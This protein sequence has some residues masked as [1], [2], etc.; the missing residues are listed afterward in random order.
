[1]HRPTA[2]GDITDQSDALNTGAITCF[3]KDAAGER[4]LTTI[5][6][7]LYRIVAAN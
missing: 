4:A 7:D 3:G 2:I 6:G 1:M 5:A